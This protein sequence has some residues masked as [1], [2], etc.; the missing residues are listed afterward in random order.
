MSSKAFNILI[1][2]TVICLASCNPLKMV[3]AGDALYTGATVKVDGPHLRARDKKELKE[4]L[5]AMTRPRPNTRILGIPFKLLL[6][7]SR[8][9]RKKLGEPPVLLSQ[10]N[11]E[12]KTV[13]LIIFS[14]TR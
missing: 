3:P 13:D 11:L 12:H 5:T 10:L 4:E 2:A 6:N 9:F 8:L 7:N 14:Q 1:V